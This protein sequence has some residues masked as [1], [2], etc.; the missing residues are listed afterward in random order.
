MNC[1]EKNIKIEKK[2]GRDSSHHFCLYQCAN[3]GGRVSAG[4]VWAAGAHTHLSCSTSVRLWNCQCHIITVIS[5]RWA[6]T[7]QS[8]THESW[9]IKRFGSLKRNLPSKPWLATL[10]VNLWYGM[11]E[12]ISLERCDRSI[13]IWGL[14]SRVR[15]LLESNSILQYQLNWFSI[16]VEL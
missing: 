3:H 11:R 1:H 16:D 6:K 5:V 14:D 7:C 10:Q 2:W 9:H 13:E 4:P 15:C 12:R 8:K